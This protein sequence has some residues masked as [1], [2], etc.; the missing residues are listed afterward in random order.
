MQCS[1][2]WANQWCGWPAEQLDRIEEG[3]D[4]INADMKEAEKNL[5]GME[6]CCGLCVLPCNKWVSSPAILVLSR[7]NGRGQSSIGRGRRL[8]LEG[9]PAEMCFRDLLQCEEEI[10]TAKSNEKE[11]LGSMFKELSCYQW[12][13]V[14][15]VQ[16][17]RMWACIQVSCLPCWWWAVPRPLW[18]SRMGAVRG[19]LPQSFLNI[20]GCQVNLLSFI[21]NGS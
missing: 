20:Q 14:P 5:T 17:N 9:A 7:G 12:I 11:R 1:W 8:V 3:M 2:S 21:S 6:K 13:P 16:C 19:D 15:Q 4:Q 18:L 10:K